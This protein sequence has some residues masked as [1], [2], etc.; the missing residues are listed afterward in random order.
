MKDRM[1]KRILSVGM[2]ILLGVALTTTACIGTLIFT[3]W[4]ANEKV[5]SNVNEVLN[6]RQQ[7]STNLRETIV[8]IQDQMLSFTQYLKID[9]KNEIRV[10]LNDN[11]NFIKVVEFQGRDS[12][13]TLFD[14]AQRRDLTKHRTVVKED[15]INFNVSFGVFGEDGA[16]TNSIETHVYKLPEGITIGAIRTQLD[17]ISNQASDGN[18][19]RKSLT[20]LGAVIADEALKAELTR[21]EILN[22]T[23]II[24]KSEKKLLE[25]KRY[26][27]KFILGVS[28]VVCFINLLV[29]FLLTKLVVERPLRSLIIVIDQLGAGMF[30]EIPWQKRT[31]QIGVLAGAINNFKKA[32]MEIR[33]ESKRKQKEKGAIDET[34]ETISLTI[35]D[36]E[37]K[38]RNLDSMSKDMEMLAT[39]TSSKSTFV[40]KRANNAAKMSQRAAD[41]TDKLQ[42]SVCGIQVEVQRQNV[43]VDDL[44]AY[45]KKSKNVIDDL[46]RAANDINTIVTIVREISDQTKLL[47]LNA[48]IEAARA[49]KYGH[50]FAV[51][52]REVKELSYETEQATSNIS[53]KIMTIEI[54]CKQMI[55]IIRAI[56]NQAVCLNEISSAIENALQKQRNDT[57]TIAQLVVST[58]QDSQDVSEQI[59]DVRQDASK[60]KIIS[61]KVSEDTEI[62]STQLTSLL[63]NAKIGLQD[64]G[65]LDKAA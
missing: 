45:T 32:L 5:T 42:E 17:E 64:I 23:D 18:A 40:E 7:D 30:P 35:N 11:F 10:W 63:D 62:I 33:F 55:T 29:I 48:T 15:G 16:F 24:E 53:E 25:T 9:P 3:F 39:T 34:L 61:V 51:V 50:G 19:L 2:K 26:Y 46:N 37:K 31:D 58:S 57:E 28:G 43:V 20:K 21:T 56:D 27:K 60:A 38:A 49:G 52:A 6:I 36:I 8:A 41:F 54:V 12:W 1:S 44:S 65:Q 14:R 4:Q 13:K 22:F 59:K 47:A